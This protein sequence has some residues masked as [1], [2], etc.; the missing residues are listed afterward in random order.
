MSGPHQLSFPLPAVPALGR[1][2][3]IEAP[4]N[5]HALRLIDVWPDWP[6]PRLAL[7]GPPASGKSH[8]VQ[9]WAGRAQAAIVAARDLTLADVANL[10]AAVAVEDADRMFGAAEAQEALFHLHNRL[11]AEGGSLLVTGVLAPAR[12][13]VA[14]PDLASRLQAMPL[15]QLASPD[16]LLLGRVLAKLFEDRQIAPP[17]P[18]IPYLLRRM[19]R[20]FAAARAVVAEL[21]HRALSENRPIGTTLAGEI[22]G[23]LD[24]SPG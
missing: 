10:P 22:L 11:A 16:D 23:T 9:I 17:P 12:W 15:A 8:L 2:A 21:D 19:E 1:E 3:F 20:S 13:S 4:C 6:Q 5:Q 7:C 18:L 24:P 14:L